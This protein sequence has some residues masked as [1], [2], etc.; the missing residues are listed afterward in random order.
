MGIE[1]GESRRAHNQSDQASKAISISIVIILATMTTLS[2]SLFLPTAQAAGLALSVGNVD[3]SVN[4]FGVITNDIAWNWVTQSHFVY[5]SFLTIY[6]SAYPSGGGSTEVANGYGSGTGDFTIDEPNIYIEN[7][8]VQETYASFRQTG[9]TGVSDDLKIY[10]RAYTEQDQDWA[11]IMWEIE[12]IYGQDILD[13]R[14][15]MN[16]RVRIADTPGDDIDY[17]DAGLAT[18]S[19]LDVTT[20]TTLM[21][22]ASAEPNLPLNHY[23]GGAAGKQGAVDPTSDKSL[24]ASL[25]TNQVVAVPEEITCMVGWEVGTLPMGSS[26]SLPLVIAF[27]GNYP[28]AGV[29]DAK[30]FLIG[31]TT[32]LSITEVQDTG[33]VGNG[34]VEAMNHGLRTVSDSEIYLSPDGITQWGSGTWSQTTIS[35]GDYSVYSLGPGESFQNSEGGAVSLHYSTGLEFDSVSFGQAGRATDPLTDESVCRYWNGTGYTDSWVRDQTPTFG[36]QNDCAGRLEPPPIVLNEVYFNANI[37]NERFIELFYPG[38]ASIS[39]NGWKLVVDSEYVLPA[40]TLDTNKRLLVLRGMGFPSGFD[41]DDG[42]VNGDN[43]YLYD[44]LDR[45]ADMAGWS[46]AHNKGESMTR[47]ADT[48]KWDYDG[49]DDASSIQAGWTF[50]TIPSL[51]LDLFITEVQDLDTVGSEKIEIFNYGDFPLMSSGIYLS[52]DGVAKWTTGTWSKT[53]FSPGEYSFYTVGPGE[54]FASE[55]GGMVS[56]H[57]SSGYELDSVSFGQMGPVPDPLKDESVSRYWDGAAYQSEW[58]RDPTPTFGVQNDRMGLHPGPQ[59][60]LK[61]VHFNANSLNDR[62][63][64]L[65]YKGGGT[66]NTNGW[67]LVVDSELIM[68][69]VDM[70][71]DKNHF[72]LRGED[73]PT[74]FGMDDGTV[75][76][77]NVYLYDDLGRLVDM[78]GWSSAHTQDRSVARVQDQVLWGYDGFDDVSSTA[79][80][81]SFDSTLTPETARMWQDESKWGSVGQIV[82]YNVTLNYSGSSADVF[83]ITYTTTLGWQ[84]DLLDGLGNPIVDHDSDGVPDSD[85]MLWGD[86]FQ[87]KV[88]VHIPPDPSTGTV[89]VVRAYAVSSLNANVKGRVVLRTTAV[90]PPF[91]VLNKT[92]DPDTIWIENSPLLP[93]ETTIKLNVTGRGIPLVSGMPQDTVFVIDNS[94]SMSGNDPSYQR[95]VAAKN[96]VDMMILPDRAATVRFTSTALLVNG[97]HLTS[98]Y[99]QV[100]ADIDSFPG[101]GGGTNIGAGISVANDELI[102]YGDPDHLHIQILI[103]DG[104]AN[105]AAALQEAQ[106]AADNGII[107]FT[108]GL[109]NNTDGALLSQIASLTG[110]EYLPAPTADALNDIYIKIFRQVMNVAGRKVEAPTGMNP[111]IRDAL[112]PYIHYVPGSFQDESANPLP[113]DVVTV[114]PDGSTILDWDVDVILINQSWNVQYMVTSSKEGLVLVGIHPDARVNYTKW[115]NS[116]ATVFFPDVLVNVLVPEPVDPPILGI[117]ADQNDVRLSWTIPGPNIS[118]YLIYRSPDQRG[119]DFS[120]S[121][122]S[123]LGDVNP[124]RTDWTDL[125]AANPNPREYYYSVRAVNNLGIKSITSN[126]VGKWT[127]GFEPG[128]NAFSLPLEPIVKH[129]IGWYASSIPNAEHIDWMDASDTWIRHIRGGPVVRSGMLGMREGFQIFLSAPSNFTFVGSPASM[130]KYHEGVGESLNFRR[131]LTAT[132]IQNNVKL[133]WRAAIGS[134]GYVV[135]RSEGRMDFHQMALTPIITLG[136]NATDWIDVGVMSLASE[137]Y[138]MVIP[139]TA[140][141]NEGGSTFSIGVISVEYQAGHNAMG[142]PLEPIAVWTLDFYCEIMMSV[143]GM[144]YI[145]VGVWKFHATEMPAGIYDPFI[146]QGEAYQISVEGQPSRYVYVGY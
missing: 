134:T 127:R 82:E 54:G 22:L 41:M 75:S 80:G 11:I 70:D 84:V 73:F 79:A 114:N 45:L 62:F 67:K 103:T 28:L 123:T 68:T 94:G 102:S 12:N 37:P 5:K 77:D 108:I 57:Y 48:A 125:G 27:G 24:Y 145:V 129:D 128:L 51:D 91:L 14:V 61:E 60:V 139:L 109:G 81:W 43:V 85:A 36:S 7:G 130:I 97:H 52:P 69:A 121:F 53:T 56:L 111:M 107:I 131:G 74:D 92:A 8:A 72:V 138:Y 46:S 18:Y 66:I 16:F 86:V 120:Q 38:T 90:V 99:A 17:W 39:T 104:R 65:Y 71:V 9:V 137:W 15:G 100:K 133:Y 21:G 88:H 26:V 4:D 76:G 119:F 42:T 23:Y 3:F 40:V 83:D 20:G 141:G 87:L 124:Q 112:P 31:R 105:N 126:T 140:G 118:N 35:P 132:V 96:Y 63:I 98:D 25:M 32:K 29:I 59:V 6:H 1:E 33:S 64:E 116:S 143:T 93:Q 49:F 144:A 30:N 110:G 13:L 117:D 78:V 50:G 44:P 58:V 146:E 55:E 106:R 34:K 19:I 136:P 2:G 115:D 142:L 135:Y 101:S 89:D 122:Y 47:V 95:L 113:P 10:Q